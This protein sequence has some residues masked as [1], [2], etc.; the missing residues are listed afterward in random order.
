MMPQMDTL[1]P[2]PPA[3]VIEVPHRIVRVQDTARAH[4]IFAQGVTA[5]LVAV[6]VSIDSLTIAHVVFDGR[7]HLVFPWWLRD[8]RGVPIDLPLPCARILLFPQ[9]PHA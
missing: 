7:T 8:P 2:R 6:E 3:S 5:T 4:R 9:R 1:R